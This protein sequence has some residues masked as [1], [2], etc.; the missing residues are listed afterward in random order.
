MPHFKVIRDT[1]G[2][3]IT[4]DRIENPPKDR[5]QEAG[6]SY[7]D[8]KENAR[9]LVGVDEVMDTGVESHK[10]LDLEDTFLCSECDFTTTRKTALLSHIRHNHPDEESADEPEGE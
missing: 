5:D 4:T 3:P 1:E 6:L 10:K 9:K 7:L 2:R 8:R